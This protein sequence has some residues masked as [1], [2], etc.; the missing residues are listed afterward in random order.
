MTGRDRKIIGK[1]GHQQ[2]G[3]RASTVEA[4]Q[5]KKKKKKNTK[6]ITARRLGRPTALLPV[7]EIG[8]TPAKPLINPYAVPRRPTMA[9]GRNNATKAS[10]PAVNLTCTAV[11]ARDSA[12]PIM[13]S[14]RNPAP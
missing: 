2:K 10:S 8:P 5:E 3:N 7:I 11:Q 4:I 12:A 1:L 6:K 9:L 14:K 13:P